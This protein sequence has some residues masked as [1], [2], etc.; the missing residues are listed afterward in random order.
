MAWVERS[1]GR[2]WRVASVRRLRSGTS[3]AVHLLRVRTIL[4]DTSAVVLRRFVRLDWFER[5]PDVAEREAHVLTALERVHVPA[6]G[7]IA[8]DPTGAECDVAAV[9]MTRVP[10]R[11]D[12]APRDLNSYVRALA[13]PLPALHALGPVPGVP[14]YYPYFTDQLE[15]PPGPP[16]WAAQPDLWRA[17]SAVV[18]QP[19][20]EAAPTFI[21][22]D[23]HP[24]NVL[25]TRGSLS[26]LTDWVN[27]SNGP[28]SID[29]SHCRWNLAQLFGVPAA[30]AFREAYEAAAGV[31]FHPFWDVMNAIDGGSPNP[32]QWHDAGRDDLDLRTLVQRREEYLALAL[33]RLC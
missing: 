15:Q 24:G 32:A 17:A 29:V 11:I 19:W 12:L 13:E 14:A 3:A 33:R 21:H 20:P 30:E 25:W 9:L 1:L 26:G 10:G 8:V 7:L 6:P 4:G 31:Q 22:R 27:A 16:P 18:T 23:Y 5:E 2:G 28:A